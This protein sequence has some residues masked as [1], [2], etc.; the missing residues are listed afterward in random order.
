VKQAGVPRLLVVGGAGSLEVQP[1]LQLV[2]A[3]AFRA[4]KA[5]GPGTREVLLCSC[6]RM[7]DLDWTNSVGGE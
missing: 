5:S 7:A 4:Y 6:Y 3:P 1:G 2:D